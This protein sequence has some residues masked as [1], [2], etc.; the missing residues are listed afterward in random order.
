VDQ[1]QQPDR[2]AGR[3]AA[4]ATRRALL[5]G[6]H[7]QLDRHL[8]VVRSSLIDRMIKGL[9]IIALLGVPA[10]L[11]RSLST[12]WVPLYG[13][14]L[15]MGIVAVSLFLYRERLS[16]R[17]KATAV[18]VIFWVVGV[19]GLL[20]LG[21]A[22]AGMWWLVI[23]SLLMSMLYSIRAGL[24]VMGLVLVVMS[25]VGVAFYLGALPVP[26]TAGNYLR[27]PKAWASAIIGATLMPLI[28]FQ[29]VAALHASTIDL[30]K[31][32]A[33]Q[34]ALIRDLATHDELTGVPGLTLALDRLEQ[35]LR[36]IPRSGRKVGLLFIDLDGFK[37][38]NDSHGH[39]AGDSVLMTVARRLR[40][41][42]RSEDTVARIGGDEFLVILTGLGDSGDTAVIAGKL[43]RLLGEAIEYGDQ[44][45]SVGCSI[46]VAFAADVSYDAEDMIRAADAAMYQAKRAGSNQIR[47]APPPAR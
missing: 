7:E 25:L 12:G 41:N 9:A 44:T 13:L 46:G 5:F 31:Q 26:S 14:H 28:V 38:I 43:Q 20:S 37:A 11:T 33:E 8:D 24:V 47:L 21:L 23:S 35:S 19:A 3:R 15:L 42:L 2:L 10:S 39:E 34:R 4:S 22:G 40:L 18:L 29:A 6:R 1:G 32:S 30:L 27:S 45:I 36:A 16:D 17:F